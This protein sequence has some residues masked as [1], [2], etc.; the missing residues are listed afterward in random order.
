[1]LGE[2][3]RTMNRFRGKIPR[4]I[5]GQQIAVLEKH[6]VF[7][8]FPALQLAEDGFE[9]RAKRLGGHWIKHLA[10]VGVARGTLDTI[11][12]VQIAFCTP[13]VKVEKRWAFER[14]HGKARH[15]GIPY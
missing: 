7:K 2:T 9:R 10:Q 8:R 14:K 3:R 5:Q 11:D 15:E 12:R 6:H 13:L 4:A 1:M